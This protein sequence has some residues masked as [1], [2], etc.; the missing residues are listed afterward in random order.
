MDVELRTNPVTS[1]TINDP[2]L[3]YR[4]DPCE[5]GLLKSAPA[6]QS[7]AAVSAHERGNLSQFR[8]EAA[9]A[10]RMVVQESITFT[11]GVDG[12]FTSLRAGRTEVV[13]VPLPEDDVTQTQDIDIPEKTSQPQ[14][15]TEEVV[16]SDKNISDDEL[17]LLTILSTI[18]RQLEEN[19]SSEKNTWLESPEF[20]PR[21]DS[22][23]GD[24]ITLQQ[25]ETQWDESGPLPSSGDEYTNIGIPADY[26]SITP[27]IEQP[28]REETP[29]QS[30]AEY[31]RM[32]AEMREV[33]HK[34]NELMIRR[35]SANISQLSDVLSGV[36]RQNVDMASKLVKVVNHIGPYSYFPDLSSDIPLLGAAIDFSA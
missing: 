23:Q 30:K 13:S 29:P 34:L 9:V 25:Q 33:Q 31:A 5:P 17:E 2:V 16:E 12:L 36:I 21:V 11:R 15:E 1:L 18:R 6:S 14:P 24:L 28:A 22:N 35:L 8:R 3:R 27:Y 26:P 20:L 19:Q 4:L 10:G 32:Q 7:V